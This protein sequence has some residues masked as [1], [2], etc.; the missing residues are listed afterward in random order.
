MDGGGPIPEGAVGKV[1]VK[2]GWWKDDGAWY[3]QFL[4]NIYNLYTFS[5]IYKQILNISYYF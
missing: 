5:I 1:A 2:G 3:E 4:R